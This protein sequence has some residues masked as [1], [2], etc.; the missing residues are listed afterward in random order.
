MQKTKL[1][2]R[3]QMW[4]YFHLVNLILAW[5]STTSA[6][7]NGQYPHLQCSTCI[8]LSE[9]TKTVACCRDF[10]ESRFLFIFLQPLVLLAFSSLARILGKCSAIHSPPAVFFKV[11]ISSHTLI[12]LFRPGSVHS[13]STSWLST[14]I[15]PW[16]IETMWTAI[17]AGHMVGLVTCSFMPHHLW[18]SYQGQTN[19]I[20]LSQ[21]L[22]GSP[23]I[24]RVTLQRGWEKT[25]VDEPEIRSADKARKAIFWSTPDL[26]EGAVHSPLFAAKLGTSPCMKNTLV[27][28][29]T[30]VWYQFCKHLHPGIELWMWSISFFEN[31]LTV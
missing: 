5:N 28:S 4:F 15:K 24:T 29:I 16:W 25:K 1:H 10:A 20:I 23:F 6:S 31:I 13:G 7:L 18:R 26:K 17:L 19:S 8:W 11:E 2:Y 27:D 14:S 30:F 21:A 9:H 12:P 22:S 3:E